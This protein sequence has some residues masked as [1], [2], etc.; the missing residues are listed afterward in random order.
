MADSL[1]N[2]ARCPQ[3]VRRGRQ[4][5]PRCLRPDADAYRQPGLCLFCRSAR[6]SQLA[7]QALHGKTRPLTCFCPGTAPI[8]ITSS[9][10][11]AA[12]CQAFHC[13]GGT[14]PCGRHAKPASR[15]SSP[16]ARPSGNPNPLYSFRINL[17]D[18]NPPVRH[19]T[20]RQ[21]GSVD[22]LPTQ[23]N[24]DD[25]TATGDWTE[26]TLALEDQLHN[27]GARLGRRRHG[28]RCGRRLRSDILFASLHDRSLVVALADA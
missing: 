1:R 18:A 8:S 9:L 2:Q 23:S 15:K 27:A 26:F 12:A 3:S 11:C 14:G 5:V 13:R 22:D 19:T 21:P 20:T 6:R 17:P 10:R 28:H 25:V 24:V 4:R 7:L 16:T